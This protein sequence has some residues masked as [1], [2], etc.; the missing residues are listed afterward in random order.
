M[1]FLM[2]TLKRLPIAIWILTGSKL[3]TMWCVPP[4][5]FYDATYSLALGFVNRTLRTLLSV[6][7]KYSSCR[8]ASP[9]RSRAVNLGPQVLLEI[10]LSVRVVDKGVSTHEAPQNQF[11]G[12]SRAAQIKPPIPEPILL[13]IQP[14]HRMATTNNC[15]CASG[16]GSCVYRVSTYE[17][18]QNRFNGRSRAA[19]TKPPIPEPILLFIQTQHRMATTNNCSCAYCML[20]VPPGSSNTDINK[21]YRSLALRHHPDKHAP[22]DRPGK[23]KRFQQVCSTKSSGAFASRFSCRLAVM[24]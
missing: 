8:W 4:L 12:R 21:A 11:N 7:K 16:V 13:F 2:A 3:S 15:S 5:M 19:Q 18:P 10:G 1:R 20:G 24:A 6:R 22:E 17:A 9:R 14:Q 23:T